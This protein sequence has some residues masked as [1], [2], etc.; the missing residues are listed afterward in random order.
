MNRVACGINLRNVYYV[1]RGQ[2]PRYISL[3]I[4][5]RAVEGHVDHFC[6]VSCWYYYYFR[7]VIEQRPALGVTQRHNINKFGSVG[8]CMHNMVTI[9]NA[10]SACRHA[11]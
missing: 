11:F 6:A 8:I 4:G 10:I 1:R 5:H 3:Y 7:F 9:F 2:G